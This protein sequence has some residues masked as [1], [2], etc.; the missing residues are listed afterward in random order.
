M[1][2][3]R[4]LILTI[5]GAAIVA[6]AATYASPE[7]VRRTAEFFGAKSG[8]ANATVLAQQQTKPAPAQTAPQPGPQR[9]ETIV[10]DSWT[11]TCIDH[12]DPKA[13]VCSATLQIIEK[14]NRQ[15]LFAWV[16]GRTN[17]VLT[18]FFQT[19]T[20]VQIQRGVDLKLGDFKPRNA[21]YVICVTQRC[22]AAISMDGALV[23]EAMKSLDG[24]AVASITL[25]DGRTVNFTMPLKGLDKA[26]AVVGG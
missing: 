4:T 21:N 12:G 25:V 15:V 6:G 1:T 24:N 11:T 7:L 19:P 5:A 23:K 10:H 18:S 8:T 14:Q 17:G 20:G 26:L 9:S 3:A 22:E 2:R 13:K 16:I